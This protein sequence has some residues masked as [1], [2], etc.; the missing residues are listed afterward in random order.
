MNGAAGDG[1]LAVFGGQTRFSAGN[2]DGAAGDD[3]VALTEPQPVLKLDGA[4]GDM[5]LAAVD[6]RVARK[7]QLAAGDGER[8]IL[9]PEFTAHR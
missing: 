1:D 6:A 5:H 2:D 3:D 9:Q 8:G 4:T 7:R